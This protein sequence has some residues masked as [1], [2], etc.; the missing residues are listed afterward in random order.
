M[1]TGFWEVMNVELRVVRL[2]GLV[3]IWVQACALA[4]TLQKINNYKER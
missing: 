2:F 1:H 4:A 3:E